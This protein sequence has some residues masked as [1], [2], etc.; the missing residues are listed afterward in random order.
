MLW[1]GYDKVYFGGGDTD[2]VQD[3]HIVYCYDPSQDKWTTLPPVPVSGFGLGQVK[4]KLVKLKSTNEIY[5]YDEQSQTW[6]QTIPP[7]PTAR[8]SPGVLSLQ[9]VLVVAGGETSTIVYTSAVEIFKPDT[10]QWYSG[11]DSLPVD[12]H[13]LPLATHAIH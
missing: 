2:R 13:W 7:M 10:S 6:K 12:S 4:S 8:S 9:S 5:T 3:G 1:K 11:T